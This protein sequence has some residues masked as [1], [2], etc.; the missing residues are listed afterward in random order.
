[1]RR[2]FLEKEAKLVK[3]KATIMFK[4]FAWMPAGIL[5]LCPALTRVSAHLSD[6]EIIVIPATP[7]RP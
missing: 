7:D 6:A 3:A 4:R 5:D 2:E 1:M